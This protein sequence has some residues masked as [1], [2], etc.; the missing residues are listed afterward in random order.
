M[1]PRPDIF[2][3]VPEIFM[4]LFAIKREI[5]HPKGESLLLFFGRLQDTSYSAF[6]KLFLF[7]IADN[8]SI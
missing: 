5:N 2:L 6:N 3:L 4:I 1:P 7:F 8:R